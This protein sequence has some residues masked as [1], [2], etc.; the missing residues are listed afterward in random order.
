MF[1]DKILAHE[2]C[3]VY[4]SQPETQIDVEY[5][6]FDD[7]EIDIVVDDY[8]FKYCKVSKF[9]DKSEVTIYAKYKDFVLLDLQ[10]DS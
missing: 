5:V 1:R 7:K 2:F 9:G 10:K 6:N 8:K 4:N 3:Q